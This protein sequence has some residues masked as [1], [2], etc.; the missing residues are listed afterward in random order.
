MINL[1]NEHCDDDFIEMPTVE[2][3]YEETT[4]GH[5]L[6]RWVVAEWTWNWDQYRPAGRDENAMME[7][8]A[9]CTSA[10][11]IMVSPQTRTPSGSISSKPLQVDRLPR[12]RA[13]LANFTN[14]RRRTSALIRT[15]RSRWRRTGRNGSRWRRGSIQ[16]ARMR[17]LRC[18]EEAKRLGDS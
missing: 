9:P 3:I 5:V 17:L 15:M 13:I 8:K 1:L 14:K 12:F 2:A 16:H 6:C 11:I 18:K 4:P 7:F 10:A